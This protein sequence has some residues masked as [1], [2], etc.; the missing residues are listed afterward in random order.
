[1]DK[2][3]KHQLERVRK[4]NYRHRLHHSPNLEE[5]REDPDAEWLLHVEVYFLVLTIRRLVLFHDA[6][7]RQVD[8]SRLTEARARF[9]TEAPRAIEFRN[10]Y[11][12]LDE[13]LLDEPSKHVPIPGRA[14]PKLLCRRDCDNVVV[15]FGSLKMDVTLAAVAAIE[16]GEVSA[17]VWNE[18][19]DRVKSEEPS[20]EL[21]ATDDGIPRQMEV[22]FGVS[23]TIEGEDDRSP[24]IHTGA[25]LGVRV[26]EIEDG[27]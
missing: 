5:K 7:V 25:L 1:M 24:C 19:L 21:P 4:V 16:L 3:R 6:L 2:G 20:E 15:T 14:A 8:D 18:H 13:Y 11:E 27:R 10:F 9:S 17:A 26:R 22:T 23:T 12:H